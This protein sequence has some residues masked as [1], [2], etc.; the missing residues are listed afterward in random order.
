MFF[1]YASRIL[2]ILGLVL[3]IML[4]LI[5][6]MIAKDW[7]GLP[8]DTALARYATGS[9]SSGQAIDKGIYCIVFALALGTLAEI[10]FAVRKKHD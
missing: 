4:V 2:S 9:S 1:S 6:V 3:G 8:Y 7:T 10:S 5:G